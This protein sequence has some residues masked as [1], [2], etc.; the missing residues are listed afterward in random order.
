MGGKDRRS[1][2]QVFDEDL[3]AYA[4]QDETADELSPL[5]DKTSDHRAEL[6]PDDR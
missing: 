1:I 6:G 3:D 2:R 5:A 4:D